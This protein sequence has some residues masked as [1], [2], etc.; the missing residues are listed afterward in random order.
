VRADE[1][2]LRQILI[3]LVSNAVK[4]APERGRVEV[5]IERPAA[6]GIDLV[7]VDN[8]IGIPKDMLGHVMERFGQVAD[9]FARSRG[10]IGLGLPIVKSLTELHG[11]TFT[12]ESVVDQGTTARVHL[13]PQ[14][15]TSDAANRALAS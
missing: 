4:F 10:G 15:I 7:V 1:R 5:R 9:A 14:R 6:G 13:P 12:I 2:I 3:N 11:G 8:G